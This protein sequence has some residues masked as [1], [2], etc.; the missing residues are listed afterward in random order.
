MSQFWHTY[1][2]LSDLLTQK[3][4]YTTQDNVRSVIKPL[5][6][7]YKTDL[8]YQRKKILNYI[9]YTDTFF[10]KTDIKLEIHVH[11]FV[12]MVSL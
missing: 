6:W 5:S 4:K 2:R 10:P 8:I 9:L 11:I 1:M 3:V 7:W 12:Q